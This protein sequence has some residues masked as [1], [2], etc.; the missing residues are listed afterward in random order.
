MN[1]M[2]QQRFAGHYLV[3][4]LIGTG[5]MG[6][7]YLATDERLH[8]QVAVKVLKIDGLDETA[9]ESFMQR[10]M[11][12][13]RT[14]AR[15]NH[16][17]IVGIYDIGVENGQ[18]YMVMEY[19]HGQN[20]QEILER[21]KQQFPLEIALSIAQQLCL[22]LKYSHLSEIVHRDIKPANVM[23]STRNEVKLTDF[24][25]ARL[26]QK[27]DLRLTQAGTML[28]SFM[29]APPEQL[30]N[31][32]EVDQRGDLYS[33][34]ATLY[35]IITG[36]PVYEAGNVA[37]L[38]QLVFTQEPKDPRI[39][40]PDL[41]EYLH[42]FFLKALAKN[43]D[44]RFQSAQE[45]YLALSQLPGAQSIVESSLDSAPLVSASGSA[46][47]KDTRKSQLRLNLLKTTTQTGLKVLLS[48]LQGNQLWL[49]ALLKETA[50]SLAGFTF[51]EA[52]QRI[53]QVD[54]Q[55][56]RFSGILEL[57]QTFVFV[58]D[59]QICGAFCPAEGLIGDPA[60]ERIN[61]ENEVFKIYPTAENLPLSITNLLS[62]NGICIQENLDSSLINLFP[63]VE[64]LFSEVEQFNGYIICSRL[65]DNPSEDNEIQLLDNLI[66]LFQQG[67]QISAVRL[68]KRNEAEAFG[69]TLQNYIGDH[70]CLLSIYMPK[71]EIMNTVLQDF[72]SMVSLTPAYHNDY[73]GNIGDVLNLSGGDM[74]HCLSE[75]ISNN[76]YFEM[77]SGEIQLPGA[78]EETI[79]ARKEVV[80]A[81][82]ILTEFLFSINATQQVKAFADLYHQLPLISHFRCFQIFPGEY[83]CET[84]F[85]LAGYVPGLESPMVLARL[86]DG[87]PTDLDLFLEEA[88]SV[89][90]RFLAEA[91]PGLMGLF[92]FSQTPVSSQTQLI[93][94]KYLQKESF[95]NRLKGY[96]K[97]S[98]KGGFHAVLAEAL[99]AQLPRLVSPY[100]L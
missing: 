46:P 73:D 33:V 57:D 32:A 23:I 83:G 6:N 58:Q 34:A 70:R 59:G 76:L 55:G 67:Q 50:F 94:N 22:A 20:L 48:Y 63:V 21:Q 8:R 87:S 11:Q 97:V 3:D 9:K 80:C 17:N 78:I 85:S 44:E 13:A 77:K 82:W 74:N 2:T 19:V 72:L 96:V 28:G 41:P 30:V 53:R 100:L 79:A 95:F 99:P 1:T 42:P 16:P 14:V 90:K 86:G 36:R 61:G 88:V 84:L 10:F 89:K 49:E 43:P 39:F 81:H 18:Y 93:F 62:G 52:R 65:E 60:L 92:Y 29:Y 66:A 91:T 40:R 56:Q 38:V 15:L 31:A 54:I 26:S 7:V 12:E 75:A 4:E 71:Q 69:E 27:Q 24:G 64:D 51:A 68:N 25:I 98:G 35:E 5:A 45:M 47:L 37:Q